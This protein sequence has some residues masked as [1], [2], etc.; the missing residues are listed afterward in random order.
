MSTG[1]DDT[2]TSNTS[3]ASIS[4][5]KNDIE[6][7]RVQVRLPPYFPNS[8]NTWFIQVES[9]FT[10]CHVTNDITKYN[11][12]ISGLPQDVAESLIDVLE[13]PPQNDLYDNLKKTILN[14]HSLSI[15]SRIKKLISDEE[16]GDNRPSEFY[17]RLKIL[18]GNSGTVGDQLIKTLWLSR[19]P[20][21]INIALIPQSDQNF[22]KIL[23]TADKIHESIQSS[24]QISI[25]NSSTSMHNQHTKHENS[26]QNDSQCR[27]SK[28]E[29][30]ISSLKKMI[31]T[32]GHNTRSRSHSRPRYDSNANHKSNRK[33]C[34]YHHK[35]GNNAQKCIPPCEHSESNT[36][37][38]NS[39]KKNSKN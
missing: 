19:L 2:N 36:S 27:L 39:N 33:L 11:Y 6:I 10:L 15:E 30:E 18:A 32:M 29:K 5:N 3:T 24:S 28:L 22:D 25:I 17:R 1:T 16:M 37:T 35:F 21:L 7:C 20:N 31:Q 9:Q 26:S 12:L 23:E 34:W 8:L 38:S 13:N 14:R 4:Q